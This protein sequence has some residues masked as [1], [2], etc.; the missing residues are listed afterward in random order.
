MRFIDGVCQG[1]A[2]RVRTGTLRAGQSGRSWANQRADRRA[3]YNV[4]NR[5]P[6]PSATNRDRKRIASVVPQSVRNGARTADARFSRPAGR[7]AFLADGQQFVD[8]KPAT[9]PLAIA[10]GFGKAVISAPFVAVETAAYAVTHLS[11]AADGLQCFQM[12]DRCAP[13]VAGAMGWDDPVGNFER[14]LAAVRAMP[15]EEKGGFAATVVLT[16]LGARTVRAPRSPSPAVIV[17]R[18]AA[19]QAVQGL[20]YLVTGMRGKEIAAFA[21]NP[22]AGARFVGT[23]IHRLTAAALEAAYPGRFVYHPNR[24]PDFLD[25]VSRQFIELTTEAQRGA[26]QARYPGVEVVTY[27]RQ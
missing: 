25:T 6:G 24:G 11:E 3:E 15:D 21:A 20:P 18:T 5:R 10:T 12:L 2:S 19:E 1:H 14:G 16:A 8:V 13:Q 7:A 27:A 4:T 9:G 26:H 17:Q 22:T 23:A